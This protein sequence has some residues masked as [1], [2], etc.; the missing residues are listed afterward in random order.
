M[1]QIARRIDALE[2]KVVQRDRPPREI[3]MLAKGDPLPEGFEEPSHPD[4]ISVIW[5]VA[6]EPPVRTEDRHGSRLD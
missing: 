6:K 4:D 5:L 2:R 1:G 3:P